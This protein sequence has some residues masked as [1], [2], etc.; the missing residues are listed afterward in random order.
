MTEIRT[1][2]RPARKGE[3][4]PLAPGTAELDIVALV[5][6]WSC[7][8]VWLLAASD[9]AVSTWPTAQLRL[10]GSDFNVKT[11]LQAQQPQDVPGFQQ[12]TSK[13]QLVLSVR[14]RCCDEF[15]VA[16]LPP[17]PG[18]RLVPTRAKIVLEVWGSDQPIIPAHHD[19]IEI[20]MGLPTHMS[21]AASGLAAQWT[22]NV[23]PTAMWRGNVVVPTAAPGMFLQVY[24]SATPLGGGETPLDPGTFIPA[25]GAS[26]GGGATIL[27]PRGL[28]VRT[29][30]TLALSTT[31]NLFTSAGAFGIFGADWDSLA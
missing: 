15:R 5:G 22:A 4:M 19:R 21:S 24:D 2:D 30:L 3:D 6:S 18:G 12:G 10:Y 31:P 9:P 11:L 20:A 29:G 27:P 14:G 26:V 28:R 13:G 8:D 1:F 16:V 25:T 17:A 7:A 23:G